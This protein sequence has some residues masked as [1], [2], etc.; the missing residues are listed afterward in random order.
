MGKISVTAEAADELLKPRAT[1]G[2][3]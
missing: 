2:G 1:R 3:A